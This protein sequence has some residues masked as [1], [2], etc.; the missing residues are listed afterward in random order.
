LVEA[1]LVDLS[2]EVVR[3][4]LVTVAQDTIEITRE[5]RHGL[6]YYPVEYD[7]EEYENDGV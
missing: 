4:E 5:P 6:E 1:E 7:D 3:A 2:V